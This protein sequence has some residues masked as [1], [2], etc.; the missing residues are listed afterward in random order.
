[1]MAYF[2][3]FRAPQD[4][5]KRVAEIINREK[6]SNLTPD[7]AAELDH[8]MKLEHTMRLVKASA[9]IMPNNE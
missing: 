9:C 3:H 2:I 6:T 4:V 8:F 7:E 5:K 1:M